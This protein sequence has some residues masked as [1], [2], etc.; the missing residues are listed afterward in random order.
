MG[1]R[2]EG[3]HGN[4][5]VVVKSHLFSCPNPR[6]SSRMY[7]RVRRVI[8]LVRS[9][10]DALAAERHRVLAVH[11]VHVARMGWDAFANGRARSGDEVGPLHV[12]MLH[13]CQCSAAVV[14]SLG[15]SLSL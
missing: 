1:F 7:N 11:D 3:H 8:H 14:Q 2:G 13:H 12:M 15:M 10:Y 9:P 4:E 5:V 6:R